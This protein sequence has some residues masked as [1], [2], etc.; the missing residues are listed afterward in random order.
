VES[1]VQLDRDGLENRPD[2][3]VKNKDRTWLLNDVA[4]PSDRN[5]IKEEAE[6]K[7]NIKP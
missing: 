2:I 5:T 3:I 7:L 1:R 4:I 6:K